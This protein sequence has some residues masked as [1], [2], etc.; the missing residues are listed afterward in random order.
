M[1]TEAC[2]H[3]NKLMLGGLLLKEIFHIPFETRAWQKEGKDT[4]NKKIWIRMILE[5]QCMITN[6]SEIIREEWVQRE[7]T[8]TFPSQARALD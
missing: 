5:G 8:C 1:G 7:T 2:L 6:Q 4:S 3:P